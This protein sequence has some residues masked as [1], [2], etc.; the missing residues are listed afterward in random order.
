[1]DLSKM[2][3]ISLERAGCAPW[4]KKMPAADGGRYTTLPQ[5]QRE[6]D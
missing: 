5:L 4:T 3:G 1:M 2:T 6:K